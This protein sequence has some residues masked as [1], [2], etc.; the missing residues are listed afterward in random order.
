MMT[1]FKTAMVVTK[2]IL[3]DIVMYQYIMLLT[4]LSLVSLFLLH[5]YRSKKYGVF[6]VIGIAK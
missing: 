2:H 3:Q 1:M 5:I 6:L 4:T